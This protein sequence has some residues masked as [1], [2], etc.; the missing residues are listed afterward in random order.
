MFNKTIESLSLTSDIASEIFPNITGYGYQD[1]VSFLATL[2]ALLAPRMKDDDSISLYIRSSRYRASSITGLDNA[3]ILA[4]VID[5]IKSNTIHIVLLNGSD[6]ALKEALQ[7]TQSVFAEHYGN[8]REL[9]DLSVFM[10]K[11][12]ESLFYINEETKTCVI[13]FCG[14]DL[15]KYHLIQALIP[16]FVPWYFKDSPLEDDEK[17][18]SGSL[19]RATSAEY[20]R[21]IESFA[22]KYDFRSKKIANILNGFETLAKRRELDSI[23]GMIYNI[24]SEIGENARQYQALIENLDQN[25]TREAGLR[26]RIDEASDDN[27][28][29]EYF[30]CNKHL[31]PLSINNSKLSFIVSCYLENFDPDMYDSIINNDRSY[32]YACSAGSSTPF[33]TAEA[34]KKFLD[35]IFSEDAVLKIKM[36]AYYRIDLAGAVNSSSSYDFP[37]EY[38]DRIPNPHL[39]IHNCLGDYRR[40]IEEC[41]RNNDNIGAIEQCVASAKS[42]NL[43]E[44]ITAKRFIEGIFSSNCKKVI[45]LPDG[46]SCTPTKAYKWLIEQETEIIEEVVENAETNQAD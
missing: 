13:L 22:Q 16:R 36:C 6:T 39:N 31:D 40:Y 15:R 45:E 37:Y 3:Q 9:K 17:K 43:G 1:D 7:K 41:L 38:A 28:M 5:G 26:Y 18:L 33:H 11:H 2:R 29:A 35:A 44:N 19:L 21:I 20:E 46:T 12:S 42:L 25:L 24:R 27:E 30:I 34:R 10:K 4:E 32:C 14:M 8:F 23:E